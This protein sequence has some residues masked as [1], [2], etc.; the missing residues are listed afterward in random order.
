MLRF[1]PDHG[2]V[3]IAAAPLFEEANRTRAAMVDVLR[4]LAAR[5]IGGA[6]PD[7]P[8]T[9]ESLVPTEEATLAD[10]RAAF[11]AAA[12]TLPEAVFAMAWRGGA[13]IDGDAALAAR[14]HLSPVSGAAQHREL[15]RV[16]QLGGGED[17]AGNRLSPTFVDELGTALPS[18]RGMVRTARLADDPRDAVVRL[19]GRALWRGSEPAVDAVLQEAVA[20]DILQ[21]IATCAG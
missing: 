20:S 4:R 15:M 19:P 12:A 18:T 5:G 13:L 9:N 1:G 17:Y 3:V 7:L 11:A 21:W 2:P 8:G 10:W 6:L 14:W 16:R